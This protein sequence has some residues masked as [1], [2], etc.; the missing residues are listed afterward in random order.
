MARRLSDAQSAGTPLVL[1]DIP[2]L[3]EGRARAAAANPDMQRP[4]SGTC[5]T[6][7]STVPAKVAK[8]TLGATKSVWNTL[9]CTQCPV[10]PCSP[11]GTERMKGVVMA[12]CAPGIPG[13][14]PTS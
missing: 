4:R 2:L 10:V 9:L 1:L 3:L 8:N 13:S 6:P 5:S 11:P 14:T 7:R 12:V